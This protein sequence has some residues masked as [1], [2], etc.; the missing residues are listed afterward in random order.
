MTDKQKAVP[1]PA[2]HGEE[3]V[4]DRSAA[5]TVDG[6]RAE[7]STADSPAGNERSSDA[8]G[9]RTYAGDPASILSARLQPF[10]RDELGDLTSRVL[11]HG[12][13]DGNKATLAWDDYS[14]LY[15]TA[16]K[17]TTEST[18]PAPPNTETPSARCDADWSGL[19]CVW[20]KRHAG[21]HL[22]GD[23]TADETHALPLL[24][25]EV[26]DED[27]ATILWAAHDLPY[28]AFVSLADW[29]KTSASAANRVQAELNRILASKGSTQSQASSESELQEMMR[30]AQRVC[31]ITDM[32]R[33]EVG[34]VTFAITENG[35]VGVFLF[36][37]EKSAGAGDDAGEAID[38]A[39][40]KSTTP[41][42]TPTGRR[43]GSD[44]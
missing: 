6:S 30:R 21:P 17:G 20:P 32:V 42:P 31:W 36:G 4:E 24:R 2:T 13:P 43:D 37:A 27:V 25:S 18:L 10:D 39:R 11:I 29:R 12:T 22:Y 7:G 19:R 40:R 35:N 44:G 8:I 16:R 34:P 5:V 33:K 41:K 28:G 26:T 14:R 38:A 23:L 9:L 3:T 1:T 15:E